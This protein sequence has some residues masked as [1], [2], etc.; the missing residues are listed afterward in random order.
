MRR[1]I[2]RT[3][4][5]AASR[6]TAAAAATPRPTSA[7]TAALGTTA[8][9]DPPNDLST[10][11]HRESSPPQSPLPHEERS[12]ATPQPLAAPPVE[13]NFGSRFFLSSIARRFSVLD[14]L[15]VHQGQILCL[16]HTFKHPS[17]VTVTLVP[18]VHRAHPSFYRQVDTLCAQHESVLMEG[19]FALPGATTVV[20]PRDAHDVGR[21]K[22]ME[23]AEGWEPPNPEAF[24]QPFS[25]GVNGSP[26]HTVVHAADAYSVE[27]MPMWSSLRFNLPIFGSLKRDRAC[28][29]R[30]PLLIA[31]G[32]KSFAI[33]W[34]AAHMPIMA[35]VL[36]RNDF[37]LIATSRLVAFN[38]TDG[39]TSDGWYKWFRLWEMGYSFVDFWRRCII[40]VSIAYAMIFYV[41]GDHPNLESIIRVDNEVINEVKVGSVIGGTRRPPLKGEIR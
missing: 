16:A 40:W 4:V 37:A 23:D 31:S 36:D 1:S 41:T 7:A 20:P 5:A 34:G 3:C 30:I 26:N 25:W 24:W 21:P 12:H 22:E 33:P 35:T 11:D 19:V 27:N 2:L 38:R 9:A 17:G 29:G 15:A 6:P 8:A 10:A 39:I 32:Y 14:F 18:V 13:L 28:L